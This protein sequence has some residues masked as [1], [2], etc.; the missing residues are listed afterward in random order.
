VSN[1]TILA[2]MMYKDF[3][4]VKRDNVEI[5][6]ANGATGFTEQTIYTAVRCQL[7]K[8]PSMNAEQGDVNDLNYEAKIFL[9]PE[10]VV[11]AG[12]LLDVTTKAGTAEEYRSGVPL[13]FDDHI[14]VPVLRREEA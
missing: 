3:I 4:T 1:S 5:V 14:E 11:K 2:E 7:Y 12:D 13:F 8:K 6:K 9:E 10:Y